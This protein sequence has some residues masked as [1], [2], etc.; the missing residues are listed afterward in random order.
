[1]PS[2]G[3]WYVLKSSDGSSF[4]LQFGVTEDRPVPADYDGDGMADVAVFRPSTG[5]WYLLG[6]TSGFAGFQWGISTDI[7]SPAVYIP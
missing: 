3:A 5:I 6:S 1:M 4:A 7:P 2:E